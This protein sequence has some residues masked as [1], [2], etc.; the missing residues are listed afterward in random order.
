MEQSL[1][2][3][4]A[5]LKLKRGANPG[6][7]IFFCFKNYLWSNFFF[8]HFLVIKFDSNTNSALVPISSVKDLFST[9]EEL[10]NLLKEEGGYYLP[11]LK[12]T[13]F[14]FLKDVLADRKKLIL[15]KDICLADENIPRYK[16][17]SAKYFWPLIKERKDLLIYF[18]DYP[19]KVYPDKIYTFN[20]LNTEDKIKFDSLLQQSKNI[21]KELDNEDLIEEEK[22]FEMNPKY[23][24]VFL[25]SDKKSKKKGKLATLVKKISKPIKPRKKRFETALIGLDKIQSTKF[26]RASPPGNVI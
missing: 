24:S 6:I 5:K 7:I 17:L 3:L 1:K 19:E 22:V 13:P 26:N 12:K 4:E 15:K 23:I 9:K 25:K 21:R 14:N 20:I 16:E 2:D 10:Y 18:P 8:T 11:P